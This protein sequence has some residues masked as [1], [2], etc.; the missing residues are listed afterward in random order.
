MRNGVGQHVKTNSSDMTNWAMRLGILVMSGAITLVPAELRAQTPGSGQAA[1]TPGSSDSSSATPAPKTPAA[2]AA[3][4]EGET[5]GKTDGA[6]AKDGGATANGATGDKASAD[7]PAETDGGKAKEESKE[8][9]KEDAKEGAKEGAKE[10]A[11]EEE[12]PLITLSGAVEISYGY[13]LNNPSNGMTAWRWYDFRHNVVGLQNALLTTNFEKG[14]VSGMVQL[15]LGNFAEVFW[16]AGRGPDK[17]LLWRLL[18]QA[19][20]KWTTP[21][22]K[23]SIEGGAFNVPF[24]PEWNAAYLNWTWSAGNLFALMPY[25]IGGVRA[26]MDLGRGWTARVGVYNGWDQ[27][28]TDNNSAKSVMVSLEWESPADEE[29]YFYFN[30]MIGNERDQD[31]S[32]GPYARHTFDVYGQWHATER[33]FLRAHTFSGFEPTRGATTDGW[34][35]GGLT[36]KVDTTDWLSLVGRGDFVYTKSGATGD[37]IFHSDTLALTGR[38]SNDSTL[39]GSVTGTVD[40]HTASNVALRLEARHDR[41]DFPLFFKGTVAK[42]ATTGEDISNATNQT[43][44]TAGLTTWF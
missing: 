25:Q 19:T 9:A 3:T 35:G 14:P 4:A 7:K 20:A 38:N 36:V 27:I 22:E 41:A 8:G 13:N 43:T 21:Y 32:R 29:T 10:E 30:Y 26:N 39:I 17:D 12:K 11:K 18:Q 5:A 23:L 2:G 42:D 15:Q 24:G 6:P 16:D 44:L 33:L 1:P 28:V 34:L 37:N 31:D 40:I